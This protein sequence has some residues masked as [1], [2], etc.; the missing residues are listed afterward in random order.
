KAQDQYVAQGVRDA[1]FQVVSENDYQPGAQDF[2]SIISKLKDVQPDFIWLGMYD[3]EAGPFVPQARGAG[4]D[5]TFAGSGAILT[6]DFLK[7]AGDAANGVYADSAPLAVQAQNSPDLAAFVDA[8]RAAY[9]KDPD[10]FAESMYSD[11]E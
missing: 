1:G 9:Q 2:S 10:G 8:Y 5:S 4:L 7:L 3:A 11:F 6:D